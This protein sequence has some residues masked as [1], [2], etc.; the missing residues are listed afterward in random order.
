MLFSQDTT[1]GTHHNFKGVVLMSIRKVVR[2]T[3]NDLAEDI[4]K[5]LLRGGMDGRVEI[6]YPD[7]VIIPTRNQNL[8]E[9]MTAI[10]FRVCPSGIPLSRPVIVGDTIRL[11]V[12]IRELETLASGC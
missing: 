2:D 10:V 3:V 8:S 7:V 1:T 9:L 11:H 12:R 4:R 6:D 5:T